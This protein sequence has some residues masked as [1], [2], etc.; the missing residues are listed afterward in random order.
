MLHI[1]VFGTL[2]QG[3][4][5]DQS[6][7]GNRLPGQYKTLHKFPLYLVGERFSPQLIYDPGNGHQ[8]QGQVFTVDTK[9]LTKMDKLERIQ[10]PDGYRRIKLAV[11]NLQTAEQIEVFVYVKLVEQLATKNIRLE[12]CGEYQLEHASLYRSRST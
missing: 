11:V 3:F 9:S 1:F 12:L 10:E 7:S 5:N 2:K 8:I 4:P 6:N